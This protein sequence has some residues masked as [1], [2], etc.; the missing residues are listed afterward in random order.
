MVQRRV[1]SFRDLCR[2]QEPP[3]LLKELIHKGDLGFKTGKG[4]FNYTGGKGEEVL[5][6]RDLK[7]LLMLK[8]IM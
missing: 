3:Q 7:F 1:L 6:E 8:H 2:E 4:F 5:R